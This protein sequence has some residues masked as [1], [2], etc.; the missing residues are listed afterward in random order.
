MDAAQHLTLDAAQPLP[1]VGGGWWGCPGCHKVIPRY[2]TQC[3]QESWYLLIISAGQQSTH[4]AFLQHLARQGWPQLCG[5]LPLCEHPLPA[6]AQ[7]RVTGLVWSHLLPPAASRF[8]GRWWQWG[9]PTFLTPSHGVPWAR[10]LGILLTP[11]TGNGRRAVLLLFFRAL[12]NAPLASP[13][14]WE[15]PWKVQN[16]EGWAQ[17][18]PSLAKQM[19]GCASCAV[20]ALKLL[21]LRGN[22]TQFGGYSYGH[23]IGTYCWQGQVL[24]FHLC[25]H[26]Y[27][28]DFY[29]IH[30]RTPKQRNLFMTL[31]VSETYFSICCYTKRAIC[32]YYQ[33]RIKYSS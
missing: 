18:C 25:G 31:I 32:S 11:E 4:L 1:G 27:C 21:P 19:L 7:R 24:L 3:L 29:L 2:T 12:P 33:G 13:E 5:S 30:P 8:A 9:Y 15:Y 26:P 10:G 6:P 22:E 17:G 14:T 16:P 20:S 23:T 28:W